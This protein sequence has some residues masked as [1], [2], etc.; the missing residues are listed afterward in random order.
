LVFRVT[1]SEVKCQMLSVFCSLR[2]KRAEKF[3]SIFSTHT[4]FYSFIGF[5]KP[6]VVCGRPEVWRA[7]VF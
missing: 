5:L 7:V 6:L 4:V 1:G 3:L 2:G